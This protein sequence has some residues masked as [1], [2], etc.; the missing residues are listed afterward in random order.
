MTT[1][2]KRRRRKIQSRS[3]KVENQQDADRRS[4]CSFN[5]VW[6]KWQPTL[7]PV[8]PEE[9]VAPVLIVCVLKA[10]RLKS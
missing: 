4:A 6:K 3:A 7:Y 5:K 1:I 8:K 10:T 9:P 2:A